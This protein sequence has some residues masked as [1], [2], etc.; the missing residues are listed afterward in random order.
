MKKSTSDNSNSLDLTKYTTKF[1]VQWLQHYITTIAVVYIESGQ[2]LQ[3]VFHLVTWK[4]SV[5]NIR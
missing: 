3:A 1:T 2:T 5:S 4:K